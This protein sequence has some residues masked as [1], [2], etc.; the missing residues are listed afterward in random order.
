MKEAIIIKNFPNG[1]HL[2]M[3][4][5]L[6]FSN[7]M[8]ALAA[9]L[10]KS[11]SF[12]GNAQVALTISGRDLS[13][14]EEVILVDT[15]SLH[16]DLE[17]ICIMC[18]DEEANKTYIK[19]LQKILDMIPDANQGLLVEHT[20]KNGNEVESPNNIV[21]LG[22][23]LKGCTVKSNKN[24]II[25]GS[26]LGD[27]YAGVKNNS[28]AVV[29]ALELEPEDLCIGSFQYTSASKGHKWGSKPAKNVPQIAY[30]N[31]KKVVIEPL[32]KDNFVLSC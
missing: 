23:V 9:K 5:D 2:I 18:K 6:A 17:V 15:V 32:T 16:S 19:A 7:I 1:L 27:A 25:L 14:D 10:E 11:R 12:F 20:I 30:Y 8:E 21:I 28:G 13:D 26:L 31:G 29:I 22:D 24:I 4:P 3:D